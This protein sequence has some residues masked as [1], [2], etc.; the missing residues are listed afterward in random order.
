MKDTTATTESVVIECDLPD[1]PEKVWRALTEQDLLGAW[2][3]PN[4]MRPEVGAQ[5]QFRAPPDTAMAPERAPRDRCR[6]SFS[7]LCRELRAVEYSDR[8]NAS[9]PGSRWV[10]KLLE[11]CC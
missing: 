8:G 3:M 4:D 9:A 7:G 5:F 1:P 10:R 11:P 6:A 2:L